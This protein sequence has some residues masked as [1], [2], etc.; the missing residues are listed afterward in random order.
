[1]W[2][3]ERRKV[4]KEL[5]VVVVDVSEECDGRREQFT[6]IFQLLLAVENSIE[7]E[8]I[9]RD[10]R[11]VLLDESQDRVELIRIVRI[12]F[13]DL[14]SREERFAVRHTR[15]QFRDR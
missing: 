10:L 7:D 6:E 13:L 1:M 12:R 15:N 4:E 9:S 14:D 5:L 3:A 8:D 2:R 11:V